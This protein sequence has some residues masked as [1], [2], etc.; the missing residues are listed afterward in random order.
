MKTHL[1]ST[2]IFTLFC[3]FLT[4]QNITGVEYYIDTDPGHGQ[5][6]PVTFTQGKI[7]DINKIAYPTSGLSVGAHILYLRWKD[8]YQSWNEEDAITFEV[9]PLTGKQ[10]IAAEYF[11]EDDSGVG[12]GAPIT[13]T[14]S[15]TLDL[16]NIDL[17]FNN[18]PTGN[19]HIF[20]RVKNELGNWSMPQTRQYPIKLWDMAIQAI[21]FPDNACTSNKKQCL[22][23]VLL[24]KGEN[25]IPPTSV[26]GYPLEIIFK[27]ET[28]NGWV[29][30]HHFFE[31]P[32]ELLPGK[33]FEVEICTENI[34][35]EGNN[36][37]NFTVTNPYMVLSDTDMKNNTQEYLML[38]V[39]PPTV[40][41]TIKKVSCHGG[42]DG[43]IDLTL[44]PSQFQQHNVPLYYR[45]TYPDGTGSTYHADLNTS[46]STLKTGT[47]TVTISDEYRC[48]VVKS[49]FVAQPAAPLTMTKTIMQPSCNV[50]NGALNGT[51]TITPSGGTGGYTYN[52]GGGVTSQNRT[53]LGSGTYIVTVTDANGCTTSNTTTLKEPIAMGLLVGLTAPSCNIANGAL[54]GAITLNQNGGTGVFTYA[55][56]G[57][58]TTKN[59]TNL[60]SGTYSVTATDANGCKVSDSYTLTEPT[61][62]SIVKTSVNPACNAGATGNINITPSGGTGGYTY[63]WGGGIT[64]Q[65]RTGLGSGTYTVTVT[66]ANG[67]TASNTTILTQPTAVTISATSGTILCN[68]GTTDVTLTTGG[69][70]GVITTSPSTTGLVAGTYTFT[71]TD[72]NG[73]TASTSITITEPTA[74]TIS[75]TSGTILCNGGTT[76]VTLTTGGGTGAITTSPSTTGLVAGTYTFT[77]TD[78]NG[79]TASTSITITEP[80]AVTI[81]AISGTILCNGGTTDVTLTT[82]G[83]TGVITTSPS[84]TG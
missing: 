73:C 63:N 1:I 46:I 10:I 61:A 2:F 26:M 5:G 17:M 22:S 33:R 64:T 80:T 59:R 41:E 44:S 49:F 25:I 20:I 14:P 54:N 62:I 9:A 78:A 28:I 38:E 74:V 65:N 67:C 39:S 70:T 48:E 82:G 53:G 77:A 71:A 7:P 60:G 23:L 69:G 3:S 35:T 16:S 75:A 72:A 43:K 47:Y 31:M 19:T 29:T 32:T 21:A 50:A 6:V 42:N 40:T 58:I 56:N 37:I 24:N 34:F 57:G 79:C 76:N 4:A 66:D 45:W 84:T 36:R 52:W 51:I 13:I 30:Y 83:G 11:V 68:G 81:S 27:H 15:G 55:W 12:N 8:N 18:F